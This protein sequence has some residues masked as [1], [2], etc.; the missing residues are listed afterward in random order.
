MKLIYKKGSTDVTVL[1]FIQD[2]TSTT[3]AGKT[4]LLYS[5]SGL[6]C[7]YARPGVAAAALALATQTVTGAHTDGGFVEVNATNMPGVYRLDLSDAILASGVNSAVVMLKG[8][9][10][11]APLTL[12]IQLIDVDLLNTTSL[13]L[14]NLDTSV[15]SR[16]AASTALSNATWTDTKAGYL[17]AAVSSRSTYAGGAV[18]SVTGDVGGNVVGSVASVTGAVG[19]VTGNVGGN[20]V[21]SVASVTGAVGSVTA[22]VTVT[23]NNDKTGY[24]LSAAGVQAIWDALTSAFTTVGSIGKKLADWVVGTIDTY[25]GNTK[26]TGDAFARLGAPAGA[27]V[28]ADVAAIK[29]DTAAILSDTGTDGVVVAPASKTGYALA[30]GALGIAHITLV[31]RIYEMINNKMNVTDATGVVA[32]R[33]IG[34]T[35]NIATGSVTDDLTTTVRAGLTWA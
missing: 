12:E 9:T 4:G 6:V 15:S 32:L 17:D 14:T 24:A 28:S 3:G 20:V 22:G 1:V 5:S 35:A 33:N 13:G 21:G 25:T 29:E 30:Q 34:D 11:M 19:S 23:T 27:S 10:G 7:Y 18:A 26:Q 16:A 8:A 31:D 2:S